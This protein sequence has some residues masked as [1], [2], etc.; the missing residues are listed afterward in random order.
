MEIIYWAFYINTEI[1][2]IEVSGVFA[3]IAFS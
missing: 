2:W 1:W 3:Q